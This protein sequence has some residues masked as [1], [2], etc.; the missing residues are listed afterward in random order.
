MK[1]EM[2]MQQDVLAA[3]GRDGT[4]VPGAIGVEVHHGVIKLAGRV[5]DISMSER[6]RDIARGVDG[7]TSVILDIDVGPA[8]IPTHSL[9][10]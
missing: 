7:V 2:E 5:S 6:S 4:L 10:V 8:G 3:L 1:N 9:A